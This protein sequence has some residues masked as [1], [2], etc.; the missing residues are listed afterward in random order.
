MKISDQSDQAETSSHTNYEKDYIHDITTLCGKV[1]H[2]SLGSHV[3]NS[4]LLPLE[5]KVSDSP[6]TEREEYLL[7]VPAWT[8]RPRRSFQLHR[9]RGCH[10]HHVRL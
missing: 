9:Y 1:V 4:L 6:V 3:K 2:E 7:V 8:W 10:K 5:P